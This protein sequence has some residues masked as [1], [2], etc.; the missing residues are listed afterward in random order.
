MLLSLLLSYK[1]IANSFAFNIPQTWKPQKDSNTLRVMTWNVESFVDLSFRGNPKAK[2]RI[3]MLQL[4]QQYQPDIICFQEYKSVENGKRRVSAKRE[5]DSIG[6]AFQ[7]ISNDLFIQVSGGR[8][9]TGGVAVYSKMPIADSG[10][11]LI[12]NNEAK[13]SLIYTEVLFN[14]KPLRIYT[15]HLASFAFASF[16]PAEELDEGVV[17]NSYPIKGSAAQK[18]KETEILHQ[19]QIELIKKELAA[20]PSPFIYCGDLN[21]TPASYNYNFLKDDMQD[22]FA[23]KGFGIGTTFYKLLPWLRIDVQFANDKLNIMQCTV[24]KEKLS[25]HY[26]VIA[27]YTWK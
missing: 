2:T 18:I 21:T 3:A 4:I 27:D 17:V 13:E 1:N 20:S 5:L 23:E 24:A 25:D 11:I 19:Q 22:A 16:V 26:P 8:S 9:V 7:Y 12:R 15:A 6:Y 14:N 10:K